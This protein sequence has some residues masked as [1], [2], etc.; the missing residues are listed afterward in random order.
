[1]KGFLRALADSSSQPGSGVCGP[2]REQIL[3]TNN[4]ERSPI[5]ALVVQA[6][7]CLFKRCHASQSAVARMAILCRSLRSCHSSTRTG[8]KCELH[9]FLPKLEGRY[10]MFGLSDVWPVQ[11]HSRTKEDLAPGSV[12]LSLSIEEPSVRRAEKWLDN[13]PRWRLVPKCPMMSTKLLL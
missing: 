13:C 10:R 12:A 9:I 5:K 11:Q 7:H 2:Q 6:S 8:Q 4:S 3:H 1:M